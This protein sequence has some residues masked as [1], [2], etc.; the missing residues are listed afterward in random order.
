MNC[1]TKKPNLYHWGGGGGGGG[2][3]RVR[4]YFFKKKYKSKRKCLF[5]N[6]IQ[7]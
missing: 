7:I 5:L 4:K 3:A 6:I 1:F 2:G